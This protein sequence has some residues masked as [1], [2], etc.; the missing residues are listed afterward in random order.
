MP[1]TRDVVDGLASSGFVA[2]AP[3]LLSREGGTAQVTSA[4]G[5]LRAQPNGQHDAD[6]LAVVAYLMGQSGVRRI[7]IVGFCFGGAVVW[8]VSTKSA[9]IAAAVPFYGTNPPL[10][11][12][13]N[14]SAAVYAI[15]G[16]NDSRINA[17]IE[18]ITAAL[19]G[20]GTTWDSKV[21]PDSGHAF[22]NH[23]RESRYNATTGPQAWADT[24][25]WFDQHLKS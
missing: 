4:S 13:P 24:L 3:D 16:A 1:Y 6:A 17:G 12:V 14:I 15:Y 22:H 2:I 11:A 5:A 21:Y 8:S 10:D 19:N 9:D 25:G 23:T 7:G 20:A 18:D